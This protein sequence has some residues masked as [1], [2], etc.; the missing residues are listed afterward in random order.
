ML[1][2]VASLV[3]KCSIVLYRLKNFFLDLG[4][5]SLLEQLILKMYCM[6]VVV[7]LWESG[8][9]CSYAGCLPFLLVVSHSKSI[10]VRV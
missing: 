5:G 6:E 4:K 2:R 9:G 10:N 7:H 8:L 1:F 3:I